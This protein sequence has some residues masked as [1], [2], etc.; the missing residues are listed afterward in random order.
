MNEPTRD[1][2]RTFV[3]NYSD[4][5]PEIV[6]DEIILEALEPKKR[7]HGYTVYGWLDGVYYRL[8]GEGEDATFAPLGSGDTLRAT[9]AEHLAECRRMFGE[10]RRFIF[11]E[12]FDPNNL[13]HVVLGEEY[14]ALVAEVEGHHV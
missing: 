2:L 13:A 7:L 11:F 3:I 12:P 4:D 1:L 8:V 5:T 6:R 10:R 9:A 14:L